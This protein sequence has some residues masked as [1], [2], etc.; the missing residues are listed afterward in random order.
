MQQVDGTGW[1]WR[2][3]QIAP[4]QPGSFEALEG[5]LEVEYEGVRYRHWYDCIPDHAL[6][7]ALG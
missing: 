2:G 6:E 7:K 1:Q 5:N 4:G 3:S